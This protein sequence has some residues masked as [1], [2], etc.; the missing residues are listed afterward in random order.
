M[1][2]GRRALSRDPDRAAPGPRQQRRRPASRP[3]SMGF[4]S[5][6]MDGSLM[7]DGKTP[8]DFEYNVAVTREVVETAHAKGVTVEGELGTLGGI[9]DGHRLRRGAPDRSRP[10]RRVRRADRASTRSPSRSAPATAPTSSRSKP[11]GE[12]LAMDLIEEIHER[13]PDTHL[14]MHGSSSVPQGA[15]VDIINQYGG[16]IEA[17]LGRAGRGDPAR[18]PPRRAQDQRRHRLAPGHHRRDPQGARREARGVRPARLPEARPRGDA[19]GGR[20]SG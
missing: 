10:G 2:G 16:K 9:E 13:L 20:A 14:V 6:M 5:V 17:D 18:H 3:S 8:S 1:H 15:A 12:V 19:E 4:T 11:D 7:A